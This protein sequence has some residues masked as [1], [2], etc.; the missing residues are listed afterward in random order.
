MKASCILQWDNSC[1]SSDSIDGNSWEKL[2]NIEQKTKK[3][4]NL[5]LFDWKLDPNCLCMHKI[6][7]VRRLAQIEKRKEK[8]L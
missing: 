6:C 5:D 1:L 7:L 8:H 2:E 3:W 4:T